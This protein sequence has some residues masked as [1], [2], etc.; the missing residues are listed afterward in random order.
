MV[1]GTKEQTTS[2]AE[3]TAAGVGS[4]LNG[5]MLLLKESEEGGMMEREREKKKCHN[6]QVEEEDRGAGLSLSE[7]STQ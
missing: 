7:D 4:A 5:R 6:S 2:L 1:E 3:L